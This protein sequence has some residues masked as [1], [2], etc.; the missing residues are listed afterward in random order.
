MST[1]QQ[2]IESAKELGEGRLEHLATDLKTRLRVAINVNVP[3]STIMIPIYWKDLA[4]LL[5]IA[6]KVKD[7][8]L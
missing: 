4:A 1:E 2:L 7:E 8:D 5:F 6:N 3:D